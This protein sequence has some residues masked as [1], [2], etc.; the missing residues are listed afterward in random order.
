MDSSSPWVE[1]VEQPASRVRF[2][3]KADG[4]VTAPITGEY[5][6]RRR[7]TFQAIKVHGN[8]EKY[9]IR[10]SCVSEHAPYKPH[11]NNLVGKHCNKGVFA[12]RNRRLNIVQDFPDLTIHKA[13]KKSF[14]SRL[15]T[16]QETNVDPFQTGFNY[17]ASDINL[18][19]VRLCFQVVLPD[20][21]G[22]MTR[23]LPPVVSQSIYDKEYSEAGY[24]Q[25]L[26]HHLY[27][28]VEEQSDLCDVTIQVGT[29]TRKYHWCVLCVIP[30]FSKL[31]SSKLKERQTGLIELS[32]G[33]PYSM[34]TAIDFLYGQEPEIEP[35]TAYNIMETA[36]FLMI[37]ELKD[38]CMKK[39]NSFTVSLKS[40]LHLLA[41][42]SRFDIFIPKLEDYYLSHLPE[43]MKQ[44]KM[45]EVDKE[46]VRQI[47]TDKTLSY[48]S[49][50]DALNFLVQWTEF[51][52]NRI[53]DFRELLS[54]FTEASISAELLKTVETMHSILAKIII[55][56]R[57]NIQFFNESRQEKLARKENLC[58]AL[59]LWPPE[60]KQQRDVYYVFSLKTQ[61][62]YQ[63]QVM[64]SNLPR[65]W[66]TV[67]TD[68]DTIFALNLTDKTLSNC[69]LSS[70][71]SR[72]KNVIFHG[73]YNTAFHVAFAV[74]DKRLYFVDH[75]PVGYLNVDATNKWNMSN[76]V[77]TK[78]VAKVCVSENSDEQEVCFQLLFYLD[79][80]VDFICVE[81]DLLCLVS[82]SS[83]KLIAYSLSKQIK[84]HVNLAYYNEVMRAR[85]VTS[86][87]NHVYILAD[88]LVIVIEFQYLPK[89]LLWKIN[90]AFP[91]TIYESLFPSELIHVIKRFKDADRQYCP[92]GHAAVRK[93]VFGMDIPEKL[94]NLEHNKVL[95]LQLPAQA[96]KC[97]IHCPHCKDKEAEQLDLFSYQQTFSSDED[98]TDNE[99]LG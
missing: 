43:L 64:T 30:F 58:D 82:R 75:E 15:K 9:D 52:S 19:A 77:L 85:A 57:P 37:S 69:N 14:L 18:S 22:E 46:A 61:C 62:W 83:R 10:V 8:C 5:S 35:H 23:S 27:Q 50:D 4:Q 25:F 42:S 74:S 39:V 38:I 26:T 47:L 16:R 21:H 73:V 34:E 24:P 88:D 11:P 86:V 32:I 93:T 94:K 96:L 53:L 97:H 90:G 92:S 59:V 44:D 2:H 84:T 41:I 79:N 28:Q 48:V 31:Y 54:H 63:T 1:I 72:A 45:L 33:S 29:W 68:K 78:P 98:S 40:C 81:D 12:V 80:N 60:Q 17:N 87:D 49:R 67:C 3:Q 70:G 6:T 76:S 36:D 56:M 99:S 7:K 51:S 95:K 65:N 55:E 20:D 13:R 91:M 71:L 66:A 89:K